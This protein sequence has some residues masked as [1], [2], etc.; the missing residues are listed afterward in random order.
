M[1]RHSEGPSELLYITSVFLC[2]VISFVVA[3]E[4]SL[5][6]IVLSILP[7]LLTL[8]PI[9][10]FAS[11]YRITLLILSLLQVTLF[12]KDNSKHF[13]W[14][15]IYYKRRFR[16]KTLVQRYSSSIK[17]DFCNAA[18]VLANRSTNE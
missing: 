8:F 16:H 17:C 4:W 5:G 2:V 11:N 7:I 18:Y 1:I 9:L 14:S 15:S 3:L 6:T 13:P 10:F 12:K